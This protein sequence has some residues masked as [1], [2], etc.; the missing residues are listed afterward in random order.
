MS[1][2]KFGNGQIGL[3]QDGAQTGAAVLLHIS[4]FVSK[5]TVRRN[6]TWDRRQKN[7]QLA[8]EKNLYK[9]KTPASQELRKAVLASEEAA[10]LLGPG[11][12]PRARLHP[13][14]THDGAN[15][16]GWA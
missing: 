5:L 11:R 13:A 3:V 16:W 10:S 7:V 2:A 6:D 1:E 12:Y 9:L 4:L 14:K 15:P 8:E